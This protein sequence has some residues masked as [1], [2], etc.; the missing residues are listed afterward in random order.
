MKYLNSCNRHLKPT[1]MT[2]VVGIRCVDGVVI[3]TDTQSEFDRGVSVKRLNV[4]K[5]HPL[6]GKFAVAGAG[7]VA[8]IVRAV[9]LIRLAMRQAQEEASKDELTDIIITDIIEKTLT[10]AHKRYNLDRARELEDGSE[11]DFFQPILLCGGICPCADGKQNHYLS[12]LH[13]A[14]LVEP[15]Q[16]YA[17][18]GSGAAY[19]E[20]ILKN[21]YHD[22]ITVDEAIPMAIYAIDEVKQIDPNCGGET[23]VGVVKN[24]YQELPPEVVQTIRTELVSVLDYIDKN[25]IPQVLKGKIK[26]E[27]ISKLG[28]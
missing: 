10:A 5:I 24:E 16:D 7:A 23:R 9:E 14:G 20:Y 13:S 4:T 1:G 22:K 19:A 15:T 11:R 2:I 21:Y 12:V 18:I 27:D 25:L 6:N 17:T 3:A 8:H 26:K 28:D